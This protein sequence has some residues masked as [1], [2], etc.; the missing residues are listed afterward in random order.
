MSA[1]GKASV[2]GGTTPEEI[3]EF[4]DTHDLSDYLDQTTDITDRFDS[5]IQSVRHLVALDPRLLR[6][7]IRRAHR[8]GITVET[9]V[10]IAVKDALGRSQRKSR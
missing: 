8:Q 3:G 1:E 5:D 6:E 4:W 7:A 2:S 9:L 10:N